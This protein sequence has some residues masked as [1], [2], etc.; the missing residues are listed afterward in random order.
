M[1]EAHRG[2]RNVLRFTVRRISRDPDYV[3]AFNVYRCIVREPEYCVDSGV[4]AVRCMLVFVP[5]VANDDS[6]LLVSMSMFTIMYLH[7]HC[8]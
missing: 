5:F 4:V 3:V 1:S 7:R 2:G 8:H 6:L